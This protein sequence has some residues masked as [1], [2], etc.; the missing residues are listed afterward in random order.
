MGAGL[1][2]P[3]SIPSGPRDLEVDIQDNLRYTSSSSVINP[4][5]VSRFVIG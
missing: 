5:K 2:N 3:V 4:G 1:Q